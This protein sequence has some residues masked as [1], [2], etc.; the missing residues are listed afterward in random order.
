MTASTSTKQHDRGVLPVVCINDD[1]VVVAL[2]AAAQAGAEARR[3]LPKRSVFRRTLGEKDL[4]IV[5]VSCFFGSE[6]GMLAVNWRWVSQTFFRLSCSHSSPSLF[7]SQV[8]HLASYSMRKNC[9]VA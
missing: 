9:V 1:G 4:I 8:W 3:T 6:R 2:A 7:R 5:A